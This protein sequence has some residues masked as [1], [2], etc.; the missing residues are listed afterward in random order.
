MVMSPACSGP[1]II[2]MTDATGRI[3][4]S[5]K[6]DV[7]NGQNKTMTLGRDPQSGIYM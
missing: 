3:V 4:Y 2:N 6:A 7:L 1:V 5:E